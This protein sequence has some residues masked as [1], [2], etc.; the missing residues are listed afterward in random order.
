[1][2]Y[3]LR[4]S[5][6]T[7]AGVI[8]V[9]LLLWAIELHLEVNDATNALR[10]RIAESIDQ[11]RNSQIADTYYSTG[12]EMISFRYF[13]AGLFVLLAIVILLFDGSRAD[14]EDDESIVC[15]TEHQ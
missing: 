2:W 11:E 12:L 4:I 14:K 13:L 8:G 5:L 6:S 9:F 15:R 7:L 3:A 1:M 10:E